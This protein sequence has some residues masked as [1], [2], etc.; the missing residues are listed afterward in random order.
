MKKDYKASIKSD[1]DFLMKSHLEQLKQSKPLTAS[2]LNHSAMISY[3]LPKVISS[4]SEST[5]ASSQTSQLPFKPLKLDKDDAA[6]SCT[7]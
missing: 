7:L 4:A 5:S 6:P 3:K 2:F 1:I